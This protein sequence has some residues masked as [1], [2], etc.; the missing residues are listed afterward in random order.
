MRLLPVIVVVLLSTGCALNGRQLDPQFRLFAPTG[1]TDSPTFDNARDSSGPVARPQAPPADATAFA[2][3]F[4]KAGLP[5]VPLPT[6]PPPVVQSSPP[7]SWAAVFP[8]EHKRDTPTVKGERLSL[9]P[10]ETGIDRAVELAKKIE[11]LQ[12]E[13]K[14]LLARIALLEQNATAREE[15]IAESVRE[16]EAATVEVIRARNELKAYRAAVLTLKSQLRQMEQDE[17]ETLKAIV[18]ALEKVL[19]EK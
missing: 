15:A 9:N 14:A 16:V 4:R 13:N 7:S 17:V 6:D 2:T 12:A 10:M 19:D 3:G 11:Q 5:T 1:K 8:D 18:A